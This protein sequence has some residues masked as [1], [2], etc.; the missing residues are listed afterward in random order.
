[1]ILDVHVMRIIV[2]ARVC[3]CTHMHACKM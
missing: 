2:R 3:V 1:V